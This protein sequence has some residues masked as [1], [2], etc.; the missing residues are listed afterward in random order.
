MAK[1]VK[2]KEFDNLKDPEKHLVAGLGGVPIKP[3]TRLKDRLRP[4]RAS[5]SRT[6]RI[7]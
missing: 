1:K 3:L 7:R 5:S 6:I 4:I 2:M